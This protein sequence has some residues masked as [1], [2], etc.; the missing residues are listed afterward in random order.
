MLRELI[1]FLQTPEMY[2]DSF[3]YN[4]YRDFLRMSE[5]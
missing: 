5:L 1:L 2:F 3:D 4:D